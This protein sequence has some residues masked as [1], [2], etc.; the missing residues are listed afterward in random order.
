MEFIL[1]VLCILGVE[2]QLLIIV[3]LIRNI[4]KEEEEYEHEK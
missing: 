1:F 4:Q 3:K 2:L